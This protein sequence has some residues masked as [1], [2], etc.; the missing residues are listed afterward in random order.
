MSKLGHLLN[1]YK[2][3]I[4]F[5]FTKGSLFDNFEYYYARE[6]RTL[7]LE[8]EDMTET[9]IIRDLNSRYQGNLGEI[10]TKF[11]AT[12]KIKFE[13]GFEE[14]NNKLF[15][16]MRHA[17]YH[18]ILKCISVEYKLGKISDCD[19]LTDSIHKLFDT[20]KHNNLHR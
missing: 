10:V 18:H 17:L 11:L 2:A 7:T 14:D 8:S 19:D 13:Q 3:H 20:Y 4:I 15:S 16:S 6:A 12:C 5:G 1:E 9:C